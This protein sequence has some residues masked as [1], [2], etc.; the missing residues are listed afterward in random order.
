MW[1]FDLLKPTLPSNVSCGDMTAHYDGQMWCWKFQWDGLDF[2]LR[3]IPFN[4]DAFRWAREIAPAIRKLGPEI[5]A[6]ISEHLAKWPCD[7]KSA[8][9]YCVQLDDYGKERTIEI[10]YM[11]DDS[12][13]EIPV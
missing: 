10:M 8:H 13:P 12:W 6:R 7:L 9:I 2:T 1:P 4:Q 3:G 11:G 5:F